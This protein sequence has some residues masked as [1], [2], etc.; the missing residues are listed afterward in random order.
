MEKKILVLKDDKGVWTYVLED[1]EIVE[2]HYDKD[3]GSDKVIHQVGNVYIG[4]VKKIVK[5]IG[6]AFVEIEPGLECYYDLD[7]ADSAIFTNKVGKK[8]I[9]AS[10]E[11]VVQLSK[12]GVRGKAPTV[13]SD[14]SF[15]GQYAVLT[16]GNTR[17]GVSTKISKKRRKELKGLISDYENDKYGIIL[18]TNGKDVSA[19]VIHDE[20]K[21]LM[22]S[23]QHLR[24]IAPMRTCYSILQKAPPYYITNIRNICSMLNKEITSID[25]GQHTELDNNTVGPQPSILVNDKE[26]Y[27]DICNFYPRL[28]PPIIRLEDDETVS[29]ATL[30]NTRKVLERAL[31]E[32]VWL[33]NGA[34][35]VIQPTEALTSIDVNSGKYEKKGTDQ[36]AVLDINLKAATE[37]AKQ[38]RLRNISGIIIVDFINMEKEEDIQLLIKELK[39]QLFKDPIQTTF[40]DVTKLQ[41]VEI[42]RKKI[43]KSLS[44]TLLMKL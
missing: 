34:Y 13:T 42:T 44:E 17:I 14:I 9:S 40:V 6:A 22:Q 37:I 31:N 39:T 28:K 38:L 27:K 18:R 23:Y 21:G 11:L 2:I 10:D 41:L 15:T 4:K 3:C 25:N 12:E 20:I 1:S 30:Y 33:K 43:R 16:T 29:L 24:S 35:I 36:Q 7:R 8:A 19:D 5:N 26:L 32:K